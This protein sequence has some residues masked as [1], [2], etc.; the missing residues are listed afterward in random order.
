MW[1]LVPEWDD[2]IGLSFLIVESIDYPLVDWLRHLVLLYWNFFERHLYW[3]P[4]FILCHFIYYRRGYLKANSLWTLNANLVV[5]LCVCGALGLF[6]AWTTWLASAV[7]DSWKCKTISRRSNAPTQSVFSCLTNLV[8]HFHYIIIYIV[9]HRTQKNGMS[10][11][12]SW[13]VWLA[14]AL[15][16]LIRRTYPFIAWFV[17]LTWAVLFHVFLELAVSCSQNFT[18][19]VTSPDI[20]LK[21]P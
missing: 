8:L 3:W 21:G 9:F 17:E 6:S 18:L 19:H 4:H 15:G 2:L 11:Y 12:N 16:Q 13:K 5:Y 1:D 7:F 10:F 20:M 14:L